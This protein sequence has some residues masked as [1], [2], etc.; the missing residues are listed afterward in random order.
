MEMKKLQVMEKLQ[1]MK[2]L[3]KLKGKMCWNEVKPTLT[4]STWQMSILKKMFKSD[5]PVILF[6][7]FKTNYKRN[8]YTHKPIFSHSIRI[9][10]IFS[11]A[12]FSWFAIQNIT[13][14]LYKAAAYS[15]STLSSWGINYSS[16]ELVPN[17]DEK[18]IQVFLFHEEPSPRF[19]LERKSR[20]RCIVLS[21]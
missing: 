18:T 9:T 14:L 12:V 19:Y 11:S 3:K 13:P 16:L 21:R 7:W 1:V 15:V 10:Y 17:T 5:F 8:L 4:Q 6:I 2:R 20:K